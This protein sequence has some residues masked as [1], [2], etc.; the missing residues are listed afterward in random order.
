MAQTS[1][2]SVTKD[3]VYYLIRDLLSVAEF[4]Q[5]SPIATKRTATQRGKAAQKRLPESRH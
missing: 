1:V 2:T 4:C 3:L 5:N